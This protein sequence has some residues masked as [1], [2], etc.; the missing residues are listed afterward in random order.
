MSDIST[1]DIENVFKNMKTESFK[2]EYGERFNIHTNGVTVFMSGDEVRAMVKD[3][4][5]VAGK[6][7]PLFNKCFDVWSDEELNKLGQALVNLTK[8]EK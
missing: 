3:S 6:Y 8:K 7:I 2:N 1:L 4:D 5:K